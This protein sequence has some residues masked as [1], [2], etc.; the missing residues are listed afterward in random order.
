[1]SQPSAYEQYLLELIN[2]DRAKVGAQPLAF[3]GDLT[4]AAEGH[5]QW[6]LATDT[7]SHTGAGASSPGGRMTAAGYSFTGSWSWGENIAWATTR[8]P[9]GFQDEVLLL[10]NNLMT[11][12]GHRANILNDNYRE[13]GLGFEVGDYGGREGAFLTE[14]FARSGSSVFL[15]GVA[16]DDKDGDRFYDVNEGLGGLTLT[17]VSSTGATYTTT[18]YGSGG[19]D[20]VLPPATYTVTFSG[21]GIE[22]TSMQTTI[23]SRN[24]KLDL[25]D[26]VTSS[27]GEPVPPPPP[28]PED[29]TIV[30][31]AANDTLNGTSGADVI[32]GLG[33]DDRLSGLDGNDRLEG[34]SA[35]D[36][37]FGGAGDDTL[38]GGDGGDFVYGGL[39]RDVLTGGSGADRFTFDT[40]FGPS[41]IDQIV[42]FSVIEDTIRLENAIF[43]K[44]TLTGTLSSSAFYAGAA[45]HD[46]TDRIIYN[47]STGALSY[48]PDGTGAA[49]PIE[50]AQLSAGLAL[51]YQDFL[52]I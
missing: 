34:G 31:T 37:L 23:G 1:M 6:M 41:N 7:F 4:E 35:R 50:F 39:G 44:L 17:A 42:D 2:A 28:A 30:G 14:D 29:N 11:S 18:T 21:P 49:A 19:Y 16:F 27:T 47:K 52:V 43:T 3:D 12:S 48:D 40:S 13:V 9:A 15:T 33:G 5:S 8:S 20:L 10:H 22:T 36:S 24:V 32:Q 38:L 51:T 46:S 25:I 26:P 45:A